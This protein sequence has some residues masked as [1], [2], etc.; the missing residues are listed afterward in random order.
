MLLLYSGV[1]FK[2]SLPELKQSCF[3]GISTILAVLVLFE[4]L[5]LL[6]SE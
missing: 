3:H 6:L 2:L 4:C 1:H 5:C